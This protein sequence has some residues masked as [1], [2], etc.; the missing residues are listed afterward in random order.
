MT[1]DNGQTELDWVVE[2]KPGSSAEYEIF[3]KKLTAE[4]KNEGRVKP[5]LTKASRAVYF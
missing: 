5:L 3:T 1:L 4:R 2:A